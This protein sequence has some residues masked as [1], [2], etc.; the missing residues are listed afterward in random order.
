MSSETSGMK[1]ALIGGSG[2]IGQRLVSYLTTD[3]HVVKIID[4]AAPPVS[5]ADIAYENCDIRDLPGLTRAIQG[6]EVIINLAAAH[7]D[8]VRPVSLYHDVNVVGSQNVCDAADACGITSIL[9]T[10]SVAIYG[11]QDGVPDED[12]PAQPFNLYGKTK[13]EA[14]KVY[15]SWF[16]RAPQQRRLQMVRPTVV[17]GPG[18]RGNVYGLIKQLASGFFIMIGNGENRKSMA[19]VDNVVSFLAH[20]AKDR[21]IGRAIYNYVDK[22]DL[23]MNTLLRVVRTA[24]GKTG[25]PRLRLPY[26]AGMALASLF[27]AAAAITGHSFPVS[28]VRVQKFCATTVFDAQRLTR[29]GFVAPVSLADGLSLTIA[30][31]FPTPRKN[32]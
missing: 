6:H 15:E 4:I 16:A 20:L 12:A 32:A 1:I 19:Y 8:D 23:S 21:A 28:R 30:R 31:E 7:R 17:F 14:E 11:L 29:T 18:N 25:E 10:S 2:F 3:G 26:F 22:P 24:L 13:W 27:D 5:R 9:F